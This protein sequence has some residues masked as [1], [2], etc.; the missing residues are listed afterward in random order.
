[1]HFGNADKDEP[2]QPDSRSGIYLYPQ[3]TRTQSGVLHILLHSAHLWLV[4]LVWCSTFVLLPP[5][6]AA[7][8]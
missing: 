4:S 3:V 5:K 1:M 7:L 2:W 8:F 6:E